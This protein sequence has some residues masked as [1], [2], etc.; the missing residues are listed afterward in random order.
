MRN[1]SKWLILFGVAVLTI[2]Q[3]IVLV[4]AA[5]SNRADVVAVENETDL[6]KIIETEIWDAP[7]NSWKA[8]NGEERWSNERGRASAAPSEAQPLPNWEF[9][10]DWKIVV[11]GSDALGWEYSFEYL[12]PPKRKRVWLRSLKAKQKSTITASPTKRSNRILSRALSDMRDGYNFKGFSFR[13][14]K[15]LIS[16]ESFGI[17]IGL[18]LTT[19]FDSLDRNPAIPI[20]SS[21]LGVFFPGTIFASLSASVRVE[22]VRWFLKTVLLFIPRLLM[23]LFYRFVVPVLWAAMT[24]TI[25]PLGFKIPAI[26]KTRTMDVAKPKYSSEL[27]ERLGCSLSYRLSIQRGFEWRFNYWHSYMPTFT[28]FRRILRMEAPAAWWDKHFGSLGLSTGYPLPLPPHYSCSAC[29]GLSGL[30]LNNW[31]NPRSISNED[32]DTETKVSVSSAL[33]ES[34]SNAVEAQEALPSRQEIPYQQEVVMAKSAKLVA[35]NKAVS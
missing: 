6:M 3:S 31:R 19:N 10:G 26:P 27:S 17:G 14:Y 25:L 23:L 34:A 28:V 33:K 11:S 16:L 30:Y 8:L 13:M 7:T 18:P 24:A 5:G 32:T 12:Q 20:V 4:D 9:D 29:L 35:G 21:T 2:G 22:W 15:S 1:L